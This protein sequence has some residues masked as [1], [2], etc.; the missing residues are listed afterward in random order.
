LTREPQVF[1]FFFL[2]Q[3]TQKENSDLPGWRRAGVSDQ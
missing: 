1:F 2:I 3:I